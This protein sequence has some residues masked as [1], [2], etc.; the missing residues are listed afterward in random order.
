MKKQKAKKQSFTDRVNKQVLKKYKEITVLTLSPELGDNGKPIVNMN[1][2]QSN[3]N[4]IMRLGLTDTFIQ[5]EDRVLT[6]LSGD[7]VK[8]IEDNNGNIV[9]GPSLDID[10]IDEFITG[11]VCKLYERIYMYPSYIKTL[12]IYV[13][14]NN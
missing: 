1:I 7:I 5:E 14:R 8:D 4:H 10:N 11:E 2:I 9:L 12:F 13:K 3:S 6:V